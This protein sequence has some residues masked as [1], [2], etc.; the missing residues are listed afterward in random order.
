M[1]PEALAPRPDRSS[2]ATPVVL[3]VDDD[4]YVHDALTAALRSTRATIVRATTAAE[5]MDLARTR[6]PDLAIVDL[7]LPDADGYELTAELRSEPALAELR[8]LILTGHTADEAAARSAGADG[9]IA[10]PFRLHDFLDI[11]GRNLRGQ[12]VGR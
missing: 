10:K 7:G 5:G 1:M 8:I 6:H 12:P 3:V 4:E 2:R 9:I 11:V